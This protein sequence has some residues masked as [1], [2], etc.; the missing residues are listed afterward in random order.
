MSDF[1]AIIPFALK[2]DEALAGSPLRFTLLKNAVKAAMQAGAGECIVTAGERPHLRIPET[3]VLRLWPP[4][5]SKDKAM[6][7]PHGS[8]ASLKLLRPTLPAGAPF[9]LLNFRNPHLRAGAIAAV[10]RKLQTESADL[11]VSGYAPDDHPCQ[12]KLAFDTVSGGFAVPVKSRL[13]SSCI[14]CISEPFMLPNGAA[15]NLQSEDAFVQYASLMKAAGDSYRLQAVLPL[16]EDLL[17]PTAL[18]FSLDPFKVFARIAHKENAG[19]DMLL[20]AGGKD[21]RLFI[22][23]RDGCLLS[24]PACKDRPNRH[25]SEKALPKDDA[26]LRCILVTPSTA[27]ETSN[28]AGGSCRLLTPF[29]PEN[30]PWDRT[31]SPFSVTNRSTGEVIRGRQD[32][33]LV[34]KADSCIQAALDPG[35]LL[36]TEKRRKASLAVYERGKAEALVINAKVDFLKHT[37]GRMHSP[38]IEQF[39]A[40]RPASTTQ[41]RVG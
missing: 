40:A 35:V 25:S 28:A 1:T 27:D 26:Q 10:A 36:C 37:M 17:L 15:P 14:H 18:A 19:T 8:A 7:L 33:P 38:E 31:N 39:P 29:V 21:E 13:E 11:A 5:D 3:K 23:G 16:Y 30:A 20:H 24:A 4:E 9:V 41:R 34:L 2:A 22:V 12:A 32:F 6:Q